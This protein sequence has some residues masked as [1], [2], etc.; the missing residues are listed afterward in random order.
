MAV[1]QRVTV[2]ILSENDFNGTGIFASNTSG[3]ALPSSIIKKRRK[4]ELSRNADSVLS[5]LNKASD[6]KSAAAIVKQSEFTALKNEVSA[7]KKF[8]LQMSKGKELIQGAAG[9]TVPGGVLPAGISGATRFIPGLGIAIAVA[10]VIA[11]KYVG[12][13]GDGGTKDT[14]KKVL[15]SDVSNIGVENETDIASGRKLFLSN[16]FNNQGVPRGP[17]NTENLR[18]GIRIYNLRQEGSYQ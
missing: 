8:L 9:L 7:Q 16:P 10:T 5:A 4:A 11:D 6:K 13:F 2:N 14:R 15:A 17:S 12:Q 1:S 18:D 3:A